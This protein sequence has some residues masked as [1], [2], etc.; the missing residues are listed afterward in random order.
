MVGSRGSS[1]DIHDGQ[2]V[3]VCVC[4]CL[5]GGRRGSRGSSTAMYMI[6]RPWTVY[7]ISYDLPER[8]AVCYQSAVNNDESTANAG[9]SADLRDFLLWG[10]IVNRSSSG[11]SSFA[12]TP[13][14]WP[15]SRPPED[16]DFGIAGLT[17]GGD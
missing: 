15:A 9:L 12:S 5:G 4:S 3:C 7:H 10:S 16:I 8:P 11:G 17:P 14:G 2:C 13:C 1:N 6:K